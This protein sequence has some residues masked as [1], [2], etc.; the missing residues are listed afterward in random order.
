MHTYTRLSIDL[1]FFLSQIL[2]VS[3]RQEPIQIILDTIWNF[4]ELTTTSLYI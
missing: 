1:S 3:Y 2:C 4:K